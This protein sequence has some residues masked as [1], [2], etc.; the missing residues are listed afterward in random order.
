MI[1]QIRGILLEKNPPQLL[2]DVQGVGYEIDAPLSTFSQLLAV[3]QEMRL[4]THFVVRED[5]HHL[6]GFYTREERQLF[7]T[8]LKANGVG[9]KLALTILS[10]TSI[11]EFVRSVLNNDTASLIK[12]PGIGKKTAERLIID[13]RDKL[14]D[15]YQVPPHQSHLPTSS[16]RH[17][18]L[19]DA[20]AAL[21]V[22]GYKTLDANRT[23]TQLDDGL[24]SCEELIRRALK[25]MTPS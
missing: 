15:W 6:Y 25:E 23:V 20:I 8:L 12:L 16:T 5:A 9:P 17:H 3:G 7:R 13:M 24:A 14:S 2:L 4:Y 22:L 10:S 11:D 18:I 19:Q 1:G 21:V